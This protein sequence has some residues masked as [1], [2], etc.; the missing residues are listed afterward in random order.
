MKSLSE[1]CLFSDCNGSL[2][3]LHKTKIVGDLD[4]FRDFELPPFFRGR[5]CGGGVGVCG[6]SGRIHYYYHL[7]IIY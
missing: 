4:C 5:W 6:G 7:I 1:H 2:I 3:F